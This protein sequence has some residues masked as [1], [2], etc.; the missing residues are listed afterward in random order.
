MSSGGRRCSSSKRFASGVLIPLALIVA[1]PSSPL[2]VVRAGEPQWVEVRSPNFSVVT[3]AGEKRGRDVALRFEQMRAAFGTLMT[4]AKVN[5]P[6]PL[7]I[8]AFRNTKEMRQVAP[9]WKGKPTQLAGLF[10]GGQDRCFIMLDMSVENP[11]PV[12]FRI[13]PRVDE[14]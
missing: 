11:Y 6:V 12:V 2:P 9:L 4:K 7:Q 10:Q 14:R 1:I 3:D 8:V 5:L 13:R